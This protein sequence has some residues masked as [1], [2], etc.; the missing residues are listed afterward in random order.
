MVYTLAS[1]DKRPRSLPPQTCSPGLHNLDVNVSWKFLKKL[2]SF[3][4]ASRIKKAHIA[5]LIAK[6]EFPCARFEI[7]LPFFFQLGNTVR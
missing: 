6:P 1:F 4:L 2:A 3:E 5:I 7:K